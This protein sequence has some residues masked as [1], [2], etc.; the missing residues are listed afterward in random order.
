MAEVEL[1]LVSHYFGRPGVAGIELTGK[2]H[3]GD[4]LHIK[5]HTTDLTQTVDSM[6]VDNEAVE[7]AGVGASIGIKVAER[8]REGDHVY[9]VEN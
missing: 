1:G 9:L 2:V 6:Q 3:V 4:T 7:E 8:C 5:G